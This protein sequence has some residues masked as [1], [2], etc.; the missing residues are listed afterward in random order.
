MPSST[1]TIDRPDGARIGVHRLGS[2]PPIVLVHGTACDSRVFARVSR[3]LAPSFTVHAVDRRGRGASTDGNAWSLAREAEDV[4]AIASEL[5]DDVPVVGHSLGGI[6]AIEAATRDDSVGP[7]VAYEPPVQGPDDATED[8]VRELERVL[9]A[10]G[11]QAGVVYFLREVGYTDEQLARLQGIDE[12][13]EATLATADTLVRE[14]HADVTYKVDAKHLASVDGA[15]LLLDGGGHEAY[16]DEIDRLAEALPAASRAT[17]D[18]ATHAVLQEAP[19][20][21]ADEVRS[22]VE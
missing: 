15:V 17:V 4:A 2:G 8:D 9:E 16:E 14:A 10:Q 13:W 6:V 20:A 22:F 12:V 11:A 7:V 1:W 18:G 3:R 21:F 5:G 19:G